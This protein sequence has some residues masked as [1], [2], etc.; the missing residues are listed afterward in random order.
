M[1]RFRQI[2]QSHNTIE[3]NVRD[4]IL[5]PW[6]RIKI[7][8]G[9][10]ELTK[11]VEKIKNDITQIR[12]L[13]QGSIALAPKRGG[14][15]HHSRSRCWISFRKQAQKLY[16]GLCK[17]HSCTCRHPH[18]ARLHLDPYFD[19]LKVDKERIEFVVAFSLNPRPNGNDWHDVRIVGVE[20]GSQK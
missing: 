13:T 1:K 20:V 2:R 11:L 14:L 16:E 5:K 17:E 4:N 6:R 8:L 10:S 3:A 18:Q 15:Q 9:S 7:G 12:K 19:W